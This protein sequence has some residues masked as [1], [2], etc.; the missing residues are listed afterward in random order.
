MSSM[1]VYLWRGATE[2][3]DNTLGKKQWYIKQKHLWCEKCEVIQK[4][5]LSDYSKVA[6]C[7]QK[8]WY[9]TE[10][11]NYVASYNSSIKVA[12]YIRVT[13]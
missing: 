6:T 7:D 10:A 5:Q 9:Q 1:M 3:L 8:L 11:K 13:N 12:M 4:Q 2:P